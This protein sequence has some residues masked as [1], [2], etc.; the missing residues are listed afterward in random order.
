ML[1]PVG[2][3]VMRLDLVMVQH[4]HQERVRR[5]REAA[6]VEVHAR[7]Y[8]ALRRIWNFFGDGEQVV[9]LVEEPARDKS[10]QAI[11]IGRE[12]L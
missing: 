7:N 2:I 5:H 11:F 8:K 3:Q 9:A 10:L 6:L 1:N 12:R 4:T